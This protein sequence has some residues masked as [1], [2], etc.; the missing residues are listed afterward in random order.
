MKRHL[1]FVV[2]MHRATH[3]HYDF[4]LEAGGVLVSWAVPK[5][6]SLNSRE[7]RL[8]MRVENHPFDYRNFEG[9]IPE[10]HYGAGPV[11]VWDRGTYEVAD[12]DDPVR[13]IRAGKIDFILHGKKLHGRF[14]LVKIRPRAEQRGEPWL[15]IKDKDSYADARWRI[16]PHAQSVKSGKTLAELARS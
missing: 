8:A 1:R 6:P 16:G 14:T 15:L 7:R 10:G 5:G 11:I 4:R 12:G 2:H 9:I 3:L 13:A